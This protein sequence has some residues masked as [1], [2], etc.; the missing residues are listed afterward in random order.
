MFIVDVPER[1]LLVSK[2]PYP[3]VRI[4]LLLSKQ[5]AVYKSAFF[6]CL[7]IIS[8]SVSNLVLFEFANFQN[9]LCQIESF[10]K[11]LTS[12]DATAEIVWVVMTVYDG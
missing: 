6:F 3:D 2:I 10:L 9:F 1:K 11:V 8:A 5:L 12:F 4:Y 7:P